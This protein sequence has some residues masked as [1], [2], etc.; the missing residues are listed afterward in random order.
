M[1]GR[2]VNAD[3]GRALTHGPRCRSDSEQTAREE[4]KEWMGSEWCMKYIVNRPVRQGEKFVVS[5]GCGARHPRTEQ[6]GTRRSGSG[7]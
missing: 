2:R 1:D 6:C 7:C 5:A 4:E 3:G